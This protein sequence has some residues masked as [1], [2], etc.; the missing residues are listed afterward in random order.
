[1]IS[2]N[3]VLVAIVCTVLLASCH[4]TEELYVNEDGSGRIAVSMDGS[5][6]MEMGA[7]MIPESEA[8]DEL[9]TIIKMKDI[10]D[11]KRDSILTLSQSEQQRLK[12]LEP[13]M[14]HM[15]MSSSKKKLNFDL[16]NTFDDISK[17]GNMLDDFKTT[18]SIAQGSKKSVPGMPLMSGN[19]EDQM[20]D[21]SYS[22][23][24]TTFE[25]STAILDERAFEESLDSLEQ[26]AMMLGSSTYTIKYH[27]PRKIKN[28][29]SDKALF[30]KDGKSFIL[31]V[32]FM[33][34][35]RNPKALDV[36]VE[37]EK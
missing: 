5:S 13:F 4:F 18:S 2:L 9:D 12:K 24:G 34:Y 29:S 14:I 32:D 23:D 19:A 28:V 16:T 37:L 3:K 10:L 6:F 11:E 22:F 17:L 25:K 31:E 7:G 8:T 30:E 1:M 27:F 36:V 26:V 15:V 35:L 21:V 33:D 20:T